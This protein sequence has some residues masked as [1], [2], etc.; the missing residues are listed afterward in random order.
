[1]EKH[2]YL[3]L[4]VGGTNLCAGVVDSDCNIISKVSIPSGAERSIEEITGDFARVSLMALGKSGLNIGQSE[5][6]GPGPQRE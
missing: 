5:K 3:G 6:P 2:Y 4:D 1:M